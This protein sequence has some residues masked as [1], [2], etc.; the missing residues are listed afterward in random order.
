MPA[1]PPLSNSQLAELC[2]RAAAGEERGSHR[3]KA[4]DRAAHAALSWPEPASA[5]R[6]A[7]RHLTSL[8][9]VGPWIAARLV[10]WL[11]RGEPPDEASTPPTRQGFSSLA[12]ARTLL[13]GHPDWVAHLRGDLQMHTTWSD[14]RVD[15]PS[16]VAAALERGAG[17]DYIA[18]TDHTKGLTIAHGMDE[19]R[20]ARQGEEVAV[21]RRALEDAGRPEVILHAV[22]MNLSPTGEGDMEGWALARLDLVLGAFHSALRERTDQTNRYLLAVRNPTVDVLAHPRTRR[23]DTRPGLPADW[24]RV[25]EAAAE[26]GVAVEIDGHPNRQDLDVETLRIAVETGVLFS[27]GS[28]AH[29][30]EELTGVELALAAALRAGVPPERVIA[31]R[32]GRPVDVPRAASRG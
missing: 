7:D 19:E 3:R 4:L 12:E 30:P 17:Y 25:F 16:M 8:P 22:E 26:S 24:R 11:E 28:D 23:W 18:I 27:I 15:L 9:A 13:A 29:H 14:G 5:L 31:F 6:D 21:V 10:E 2:A 32:P 1:P 20:L